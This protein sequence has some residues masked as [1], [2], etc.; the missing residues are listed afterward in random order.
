MQAW[1]SKYGWSLAWLLLV[2]T[3]YQVRTLIPIDETRYLSVAWEMWLRGDFLVPY[4]NGEPYSHKPPMLFWLFHLGWWIFG[5]NEWWPRLV[6][7][8]F[9]LS[10]LMLV[11]TLA[12]RLWPQQTSVSLY[13]PWI[14][15]S[16][17][18]WAIYSTTTM[19]DM[20]LASMVLIAML[21]L[22]RAAHGHARSG[23]LLV[24]AACGAGILVKG[25]VMLLH[26]ASVA[27]LAPMW[28][29]YARQNKL[30]W[31][32]G[33]FV[34]VIIAA[35]IALSWALPAASAGGPVYEQAILWHQTADRMVSS[36]AHQRGYWWYLPILPALLS[37][38]FLWPPAWRAMFNLKSVE[39]AGIR[40]L[41][42]WLVP[43]F[44]AFSLISA[45]QIHYLTPLFPAFALL[46]SFA[47][48]RWQHNATRVNQILPALFMLMIAVI[49]LML[50]QIDAH[51]LPKLPIPIS[52]VWGISI[53]VI[54]TMLFRKNWIPAQH[55]VIP[56]S[57]IS[58]AL[59]MLLMSAIFITTRPVYDITPAAKLLSE[60]QH[61]GKPVA[62][63]SKYHDQFQFT[64]RLTQPLVVIT[65]NQQLIAWCTTH[66]DGYVIRYQDLVPEPGDPEPV[67]LQQ[68]RNRWLT[69]WNTR[70]MLQ[71]IE[72]HAE[73]PQE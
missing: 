25:P 10:S 68:Y 70:S 43:T 58:Y 20:L 33:L 40:F 52:P 66:P 69:I 15:G 63:I 6:P 27:I 28:S 60:L 61:Q 29:D 23:W 54:T 62:H 36:F 3:A 67:Y 34:A 37:P 31:F 41:L 9:A 57:V 30:H 24:G 53:L 65:S 59:A 12:N 5:V 35:V 14:L 26:I 21:G 73:E 39:D 1:L 11:R 47:L 44:L 16:S 17:L 45:K 2:I 72:T 32:A 46:L 19:F 48:T 64:G 56:M 7:P 4:I 50:P 38:W 42:S 18:F 55:A 49:L 8:L 13:A 22:W 71:I 51:W